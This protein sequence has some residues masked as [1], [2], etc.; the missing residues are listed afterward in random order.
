[1]GRLSPF[2]DLPHSQVRSLLASGAPVFLPVNPVEY[3]GPHLSLHNDSL[4]SRGLSRDIHA[5]LAASEGDW[6]FLLATDL[7][8]GVDPC[9]GPGTRPT[10]YR[11]VRALV[12]EACRRLAE[13]GARRVILVTFHGSPLHS[14]ALEAGVRWLTARGIRALAPL[15]LLLRAVMDIRPEDY[16]DA[17][18]TIRDDE[19]R[20]AVMG[21]G[22]SDF[23]A[24]FFETSLSLHYAPDSVDPRHT[25]LPPCPPIVPDA[26]LLVASRAARR[27]GRTQLASELNFAAI[28]AGWYALRPF[29]G[30]TS[31]PRSAT[32][33]AGGII[34]R[35]MTREFAAVAGRVLRGEEAPPAPIMRWMA[36][37]TLGGVVATTRVEHEAIAE[38]RLG[39]SALLQSTP[40]G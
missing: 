23:H 32:R 3:H 6:P 16:A 38:N 1:M 34:A 31:R 40:G 28:G 29:P 13:L 33:D 9:P 24:G 39:G 36:P 14:L 15:N 30:Y 7:E 2:L 26:K 11:Q 20:A 27:I 4:I 37:V 19:E 35:Y 25:H 12:V 17:Y 22:T 21:E 8:V 18:A 5:H 10:S